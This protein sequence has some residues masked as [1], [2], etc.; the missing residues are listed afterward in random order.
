MSLDKSSQP[1]IKYC[2]DKMNAQHRAGR[3]TRLIWDALPVAS[4]AG[5]GTRQR[6]T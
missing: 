6:L 5:K 3:R 2:T 1:S 4:C